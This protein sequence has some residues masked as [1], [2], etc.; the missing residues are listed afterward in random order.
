[1]NCAQTAAL[2]LDH[3]DLEGLNRKYCVA[4]FLLLA[5]E[6]ANPG[7]PEAQKVALS[8]DSIFAFNYAL[9]LS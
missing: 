7:S 5:E 6:S 9:N 4:L 3:I 2:L 1:M 8:E